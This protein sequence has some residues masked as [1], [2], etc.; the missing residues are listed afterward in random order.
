MSNTSTTMYTCQMHKSVQEMKHLQKILEVSYD[1][2]LEF[3]GHVKGAD[4][5]LQR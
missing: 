2:L 5:W 4:Q 1:T 3:E